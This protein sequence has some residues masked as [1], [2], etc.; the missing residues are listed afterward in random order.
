MD[1]YTGA[2][3]ESGDLTIPLE[4][5]IIN[6]DDVLADLHELCSNKHPGRQSP[7]EITLFKSVG[8]ALEDLVGARYYYNM[9]NEG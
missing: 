3:S 1:D 6:K 8:F 9:K 5:G 2:L 7:E 4:K